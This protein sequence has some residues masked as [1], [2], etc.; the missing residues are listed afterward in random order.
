MYG[1]IIGT[2]GKD[3]VLKALDSGTQILEFT[4]VENAWV[5]SEKSTWYQCSLFGQ[6]GAKLESKLLKGC[7]VSVIGQSYQDEFTNRD[8]DTV[9][10]LRCKVSDVVIQQ[11]AGG[12]SSQA[13]PAAPNN[14]NPHQ[15]NAAP[16][17][18]NTQGGP[19]SFKED[20]DIPF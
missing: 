19:G 15:N 4:I 11:Y 9:K 14:N 3:A 6:R 5:G 10:T 13:S 12:S 7:K 18:T 17:A 2:I 16:P 20:D 8:N 1:T